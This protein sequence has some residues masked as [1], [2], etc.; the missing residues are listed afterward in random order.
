MNHSI[1]KD[2]LGAP[3]FLHPDGTD[4]LRGNEIAWIPDWKDPRA[5]EREKG[6]PIWFWGWE[7]LR[8]NRTFQTDCRAYEANKSEK[9]SQLY[10]NWGLSEFKSFEATWSH[11]DLPPQALDSDKNDAQTSP[12]ERDRQIGKL[13][14]Y[15]RV[16]DALTTSPQTP[17]KSIGA[18]FHTEGLILADYKR[19]R[20]EQ[21]IRFRVQEL[22]V[23]DAEKEIGIW[24]AL[25]RDRQRTLEP[26][27]AREVHS[28]VA[29]AYGLIYLGGYRHF[30]PTVDETPI[31][32]VGRVR[33]RPKITTDWDT[34]A[35]LPDLFDA[36]I[37][38]WL[39]RTRKL[40]L[41]PPE[42]EW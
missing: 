17:R 38:K 33:E 35:P 29:R 40:K 10:R 28:I 26:K 16:A 5:Y 6:T 11:H 27:Y 3:R 12:G 31:A 8:R 25:H 19:A 34:D 14:K 23:P 24:I 32:K 22:G 30:F 2:P 9:D 41:E 13:G 4:A 21:A 7:F 37:E 36:D 15:L 42:H 20:D 1:A 39:T 18:L